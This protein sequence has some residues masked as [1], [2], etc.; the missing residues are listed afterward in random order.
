MHEKINKK[1]H[2]YHTSKLLTNYEV[3]GTDTRKSDDI[4]INKL[5]KSLAT[6]NSLNLKIGN[7]W[8]ELDLDIKIELLE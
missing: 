3:T 8:N 6:V 2:P 1:L 4:H 7:S 5:G